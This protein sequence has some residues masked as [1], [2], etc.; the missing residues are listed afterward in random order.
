MTNWSLLNVSIHNRLHRS[1]MSNAKNDSEWRAAPRLY[2]FIACEG[3]IQNLENRRSRPTTEWKKQIVPKVLKQLDLPLNT[4]VQWSQK[5]GCKCGCSPGFI[6][7]EVYEHKD[8]FVDVEP[9][10]D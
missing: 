9:L 10:D 8:F 6:L 1:F 3:I 4:K 2:V 5:A 7:P